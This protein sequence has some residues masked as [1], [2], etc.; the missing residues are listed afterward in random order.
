MVDIQDVTLLEAFL[1]LLTNGVGALLTFL[2]WRVSEID[3][4]E[5]RAWQPPGDLPGE[6]ALLRHNRLVV[7]DDLRHAEAR[8]LQ[9]HVLIAMVGIFWI[10]T[11]QPVNPSVIWW[12]VGIRLCTIGVSLLLIDKTLHHLIARWR[13]DRPWVPPGFRQIGPAIR[14]A[15]QDIHAAP[16]PSVGACTASRMRVD[17]RDRT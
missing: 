14:L 5:A 2:A 3:A 1:L 4:R 11:P 7:A 16:P 8:R 10:V 12:A 9:T 6:P 15:W 17:Q 13:F